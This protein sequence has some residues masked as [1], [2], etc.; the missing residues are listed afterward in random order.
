MDHN[1]SA[2]W[3]ESLKKE[4]AAAKNWQTKYL[5]EEQQRQLSEDEEML[6][7]EAK[8][9]KLGTGR[10]SEREAMERRL[11]N[12]EGEDPADA[13]LPPSQ[14]TLQR[15][16]I[17]AQAREHA[18][19]HRLYARDPR[20]RAPS[21]AC[22]DWRRVSRFAGGERATALSPDDAENGHGEPAR[23]HRAGAVGL[24]QPRLR[25]PH[26]ADDDLLAGARARLRRREGM[27]RPVR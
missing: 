5:T 3:L 26:A 18:L 24:S 27:G 10:I 19:T 17:A 23:G 12:L 21:R 16:R 13:P 25:L 6:A 1:Q 8:M 15:E 9:R 22:T 11:A 2:I 14:Y 20:L 7:T 4:R